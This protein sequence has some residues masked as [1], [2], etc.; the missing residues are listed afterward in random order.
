M[1]EGTGLTSKGANSTTEQPSLSL[2]KKECLDMQKFGTAKANVFFVSTFNDLICTKNVKSKYWLAP[3]LSPRGPSRS[4][5]QPAWLDRPTP[6]SKNSRLSHAARRNGKRM[7]MFHPYYPRGPETGTYQP[8]M[9]SR[10]ARVSNGS[11]LPVM[12]TKTRSHQQKRCIISTGHSLHQP[13]KTT[14]KS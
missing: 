5:S 7:T 14:P 8:R 13:G 3:S 12:E 1:N 6:S 2:H 4:L 11:C 9:V 10:H